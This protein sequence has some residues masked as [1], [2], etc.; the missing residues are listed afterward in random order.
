MWR[1]LFLALG[2]YVMILGVECIT[3]KEFRLRM[4]EP[5]P[6]QPASLF[7]EQQAQVGPQRVLRPQPW[8]PWSFLSTGAVVCLYSF[9]IPA[10][11][12]GK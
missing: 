8:V 9:T 1:S 10:R 12:A 2:L 3:V 6:S 5:P 4:H 7:P 11:V